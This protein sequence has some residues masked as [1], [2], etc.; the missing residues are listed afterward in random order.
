MSYRVYFLA[1]RCFLSI[2]VFTGMVP[3]SDYSVV[4]STIMQSTRPPRPTHPSVTGRLWKLMQ[5]CWDHDPDLRPKASEVLQTL[6]DSSVTHQFRRS[7]IYKLDSSAPSDPPAWKRLISSSL[8]ASER[9]RLITTT[10]SGRDEAEVFK[11]P[12]EMM[13]T[14]LFD[15]ASIRILLP[16]ENASVEPGTTFFPVV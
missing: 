10:L 14:H 2:Q 16:L 15:E 4:V 12:L 9:I 3:F 13:P 5:R 7:S 1:Y 6:L 11:Y 8:P